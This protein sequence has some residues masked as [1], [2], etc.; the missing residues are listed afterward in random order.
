M[1]E[2]IWYCK[3]CHYVSQPI[4]TEEESK[5]CPKCGYTSIM[6]DFTP[7]K[8]FEADTKAMMEYAK[9]EGRVAYGS[10]PDEKE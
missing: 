10:K 1:V 8:D 6:V 4:T 9:R 5:I 3:R 7:A 2:K